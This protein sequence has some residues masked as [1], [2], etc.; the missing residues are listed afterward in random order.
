MKVTVLF[1]MKCTMYIIICL[2]SYRRSKELGHGQ[3]GS[4]FKGYWD[5][6]LGHL[7][8]AIKALNP[9]KAQP[10]SKVKLLQEAAIMAQFRHSNV[11]QLYGIVT[12]GPEV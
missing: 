3:F 9:N 2:F 5:G 4:V 10:D 8:V 7:E 11:I 1:K 12:E 6:P